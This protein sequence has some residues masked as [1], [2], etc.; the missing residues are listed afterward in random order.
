MKQVFQCLN[1]Y[2]LTAA[3]PL[4]LSLSRVVCIFSLCTLRPALRPAAAKAR[5][6][7]LRVHFKHMR[8]VAHLIKGMKLSK[9]KVY[10]QVRQRQREGERKRALPQVAAEFADADFVMRARCF[11]AELMWDTPIVPRTVGS[12]AKWSFLLLFVYIRWR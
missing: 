2:R 1:T 6:S 3:L 8:E 10:L 7:N 11:S 5:G 9:A 12:G 4:S